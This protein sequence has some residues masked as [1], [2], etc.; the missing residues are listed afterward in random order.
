MR[1]CVRANAHPRAQRNV[2]AHRYHRTDKHRYTDQHADANTRAQRD[3]LAHRYRHAHQHANGN[4]YCYAD[5]HPLYP[6][7]Q[8]VPARPARHHP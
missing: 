6:S 7:G 2:V 4:T 8:P 1:A 5:A 3:A